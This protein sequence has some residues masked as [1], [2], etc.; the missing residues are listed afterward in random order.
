MFKQ[1]AED[2][3]AKIELSGRIPIELVSQVLDY[4]RC[5][6]EGNRIQNLTR[7]LDPV[8]FFD[9]NVLDV[10]ELQNSGFL[11]GATADL[12][13]GAG[14]PG[15]LHGAMYSNQKWV[16]LESERNKAEFL[17]NT[18]KTLRLVNVYVEAARGETILDALEAECVVVRAVGATD[19]IIRLLSKCSTWN[20][21]ILFKGPKWDEEWARCQKKRLANGF[22]SPRV[23]DYSTGDRIRKII[24]LEGFHVEQPST[25]RK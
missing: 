17:R 8:E 11:S 12:G 2:L 13:S 9:K 21:L 22:K 24:L 19:K 1:A 18:C 4:Y 16:L 23:H 10:L 6:L 5:V 15:L 14:V 25:P 7:I 20:R 3:K